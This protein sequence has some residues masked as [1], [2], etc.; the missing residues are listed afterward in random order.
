M[1]PQKCQYRKNWGS[2]PKIELQNLELVKKLKAFLDRLATPYLNLLLW[3][4]MSLSLL[5]SGV[6]LI[7]KIIHTHFSRWVDPEATCHSRKRGHL[8]NP[9]FQA[10]Q[11]SLWSLIPSVMTPFSS[12]ATGILSVVAGVCLWNYSALASWSHPTRDF[13]SICD[14]PI[15]TPFSP[16]Y[17][18]KAPCYPHRYG[19]YIQVRQSQIKNNQTFIISVK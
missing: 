10:M 5:Q 1:V 14:P 2:C 11:N 3:L 17:V 18:N 13:A 7:E 19:P 9:V 12:C 8:S 6:W 4:V 16:V 15:W